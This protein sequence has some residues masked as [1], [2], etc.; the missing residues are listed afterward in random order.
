MIGYLEYFGALS[1]AVRLGRVRWKNDQD[2]LTF[3]S[4]IVKWS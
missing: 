3:V 2:N 4:A 1:S